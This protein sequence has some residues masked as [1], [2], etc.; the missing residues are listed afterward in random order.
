MSYFSIPTLRSYKISNISSGSSGGGGGGGGCTY[1]TT[2]N[3]Q[4]VLL[5]HGENFN[6]YTSNNW[7][8]SNTNI[9]INSSSPQKFCNNF[10]FNGSN[11]YMQLPNNS[12][13]NLGVFTIEMWIYLS[14]IP[15]S[16]AAIVAPFSGQGFAMFLGSD[17]KLYVSNNVTGQA[18][19]ST[20]LTTG[21]WHHIAGI[22]DGTNMYT[23]QDG[24]TGGSTP[25]AIAGSLQAQSYI[26]KPNG[27]SASAYLG[28][29]VDEFRISNAALYSGSYTVPVSAFA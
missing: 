24:G 8:V 4:T 10:Y 21:A 26:G 18:G 22:Y 2:S 23:V 7:T 19:A 1:S 15:S 20:A 27:G 13:F 17:G 9:T 14:A 12:A 6:D 16:A 3:S 5:M 28:A 25:T 11:A 29:Y